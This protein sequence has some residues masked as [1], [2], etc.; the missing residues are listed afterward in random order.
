MTVEISDLEERLSR[1][2]KA[3]VESIPHEP[4][5]VEWGELVRRRPRAPARRDR[6]HSSGR[7]WIVTA[8]AAVVV[9]AVVV[10]VAMAL[11]PTSRQ[12][13]TFASRL[14]TAAPHQAS[15]PSEAGGDWSLVSYLSDSS[16]HVNSEGPLSPGS[17]ACQNSTTCYVVSGI[18]GINP[19]IAPTPGTVFNVSE[20][21]GASWARYQ[22]PTGLGLTSSLT[23]PTPDGLA[24]VAGGTYEASP[25]LL[26]TS[27]GGVHWSE[28]SV[29]AE[30]GSPVELSCVSMTKCVGLFRTPVN[31]LSFGRE[32]A[33]NVIYLGGTLSARIYSTTD[34]G[35]TWK[36]MAH[37]P[38]GDVPQSVSCALG[39]CVVIAATPAQ[40][41]TGGIT[42]G[43]VFASA[44][45]GVTW[46]RGTLP[47]GFGVI[48]SGP[49]QVDCVTF[50][51]CWATGTITVPHSGASSADSLV[52][53]AASSDDGGLTWQAHPLPADVSNPRLYSISCPGPEDCWLAGWGSAPNGSPLSSVVLSTFNGGDDWSQEDLSV[54]PGILFGAISCPQR[55]SALASE[56][57]TPNRVGWRSTATRPGPR[58]PHRR[59]TGARCV[60]PGVRVSRDTSAARFSTD[61]SSMAR[62][63]IG[64]CGR[65]NSGM[66]GHS[67]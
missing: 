29:P 5:V 19:A 2:L 41:V 24:C 34:G 4:P 30:D 27:D 44:D 9:L 61:F 25:A 66:S 32:N 6:P 36:K 53:V 11:S 3:A 38:A 17:I 21:S 8:A 45:G 63:T 51:T 47:Q 49:T 10:T 12:L 31:P 18:A 67:Q 48:W 43:A 33:S 57:S 52:S 55:T 22:M 1:A 23:C 35:R 28:Q 59:W 20:N 56:G 54:A 16:W 58:R 62:G 46:Q 15:A 65:A 42:R 50:S 7:A 64:K 26:R 37:L 39:R 14:L 40:T 60:Q 13:P